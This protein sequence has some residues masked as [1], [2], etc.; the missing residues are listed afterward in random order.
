MTKVSIGD[1][2]QGYML[3][4]HN[5]RLKDHIKT[6]V[7]EM[8]SGR[9]QDTSRHLSG[10]YS[11]LSDV[12]RNL[13]MLERYSGAA[14]E[15]K[16]VTSAMQRGLDRFQ[17]V[18]TDLGLTAV[19]A[20]T[21]RQEDVV[22]NA[23]LKA[24]GDMDQM[25]SALNTNVGGRALFS[26]TAFDQAPL[27]DAETMLADLR[28]ALAGQTTLAGVQGVMDSWFD[29]PGGGFETIGY[30]GGADPMSPIMV[31]EGETLNLSLKGDDPAIRG[32]LKSTAMAALAADTTLAFSVQVQT[33]MMAAAGESLTFGQTGL[34]S[35]RGDLGYAEARV[36]EAQT[37]LSAETVSYQIARTDLLSVDPY[38]TVTALEDAR[39]QLESLYNVTARLSRLSLVEYL[40]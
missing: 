18:S 24:R 3:R 16:V 14:S 20:A 10:T 40:R 6:L 9:A 22:R 27:A 4:H 31:A 30:T 23:S 11:F 7:Q 8:A 32:L 21:T 33:E 13:E 35:I 36:E 26:G 12:E 29:S 38:E 28:T 1:M 34:T 5:V 37:R 25:I 15:A 39:Y 2:A 17:Q 19:T